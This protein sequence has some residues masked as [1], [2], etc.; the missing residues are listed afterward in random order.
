M[1]THILYKYY[2][3]PDTHPPHTVYFITPKNIVIM[4]LNFS[5]ILFVINYFMSQKRV[6]DVFVFIRCTSSTMQVL[7][8]LKL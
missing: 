3:N 7:I 5:V 2:Y 4:A 8:N 6:F 1:V